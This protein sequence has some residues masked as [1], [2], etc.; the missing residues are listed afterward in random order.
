M[1]TGALRHEDCRALAQL[2]RDGGERCLRAAFRRTRIDG[3]VR[4]DQDRIREPEFGD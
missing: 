3:L 1:R 4:P 2:P